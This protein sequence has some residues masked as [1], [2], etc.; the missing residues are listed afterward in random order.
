MGNTTHTIKHLSKLE[1]GKDLCKPLILINDSCNVFF[2]P[3]SHLG[4][5]HQHFEAAKWHYAQQ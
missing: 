2:F 5:L 1:Y 4:L 3:C